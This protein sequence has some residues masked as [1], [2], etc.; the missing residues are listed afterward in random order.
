MVDIGFSSMLASFILVLI[1]LSCIAGRLSAFLSDIFKREIIY[2]IGCLGIIISF[3]MLNT[4]R[5][6]T[7]VW[8]LYTYA[9]LFGFFGGII[10]PTFAS[11]IANIFG[12]KSFGTIFGIYIFS[13]GIGFSFGAWIGGYIF[14]VSES[15]QFA[16]ILSIILMAVAGS[17]FWLSSLGRVRIINRNLSVKLT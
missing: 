15:Y 8:N 13:A 3:L 14:D 2:S 17:F 4:A 9:I 16:I 6:N 11:A 7:N 12:G 10:T 1:G 5:D